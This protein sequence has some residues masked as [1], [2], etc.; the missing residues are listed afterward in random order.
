MLT[1]FQIQSTYPNSFLIFSLFQIKNKPWP[2]PRTD[3]PWGLT[4][5]WFDTNA[6]I[7]GL[8]NPP[9][10]QM[11]GEKPLDIVV[12][13]PEDRILS[14]SH[15]YDCECN[16]LVQDNDKGMKYT[17]LLNRKNP[18]RMAKSEDGEE[19][20]NGSTLLPFITK[21]ELQ[22]K[23]TFTLEMPPKEGFY[24]LQIFARRRPTKKCR[25]KIPLAA[26]ILL[27]FRHSAQKVSHQTR[28]SISLAPKSARD[29]HPGGSRRL[30]SVTSLS[31]KSVDD[32]KNSLSPVQVS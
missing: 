1:N 2:I 14:L 29:L 3:V 5:A 15:I 31:K 12:K 24:K 25:L 23:T 16:E 32:R 11:I 28:N 22:D 30:Q 10:I 26:N 6:K 21:T 7:V 17:V 13:T 8:S 20:E 18:M 4:E 27:E 19:D 9:I